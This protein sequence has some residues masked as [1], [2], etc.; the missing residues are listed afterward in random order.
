MWPRPGDMN[1]SQK[2][3]HHIVKGKAFFFLFC[4]M[5]AFS[6]NNKTIFVQSTLNKPDEKRFKIFFVNVFIIIIN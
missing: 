1:Q 4:E 2:A 5:A 3:V 6:L